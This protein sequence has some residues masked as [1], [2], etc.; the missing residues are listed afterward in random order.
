[1]KIEKH[2]FKSSIYNEKRSFRIALPVSAYPNVKY[3]ILFVLDAD[4]TF[5]IIASN[6]IY[7]Q[8][9][10]IIPPTAV[11]AIDY[12]TPGNRN[13]V[14]YDLS[15]N[16]LD[17]SGEQFY[18]YINTDLA[19]EINK[20]LPTSGFNTLVGHSYTASYLNYYIDAGNDFIKSYILFSPEEMGQIPS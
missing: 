5:D 12:S 1:M 9:F 16:S 14:G 7:L 19:R 6:A 2:S 10:D 13:D 3:N 18:N 15:N 17:S 20:I 11:V 4:Y 8:T